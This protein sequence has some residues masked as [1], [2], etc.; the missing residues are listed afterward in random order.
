MEDIRET[1]LTHSRYIRDTLLPLVANDQGSGLNY[2]DL[3]ILRAILND[4]NATPVTLELLRYSRIAKALAIITTDT[5]WPADTAMKASRIL[6][7]WEKPL[8][9]VDD[10][11]IDLWGP[12]G[13][14]EGLKKA[15][16]WWP[17]TVSKIKVI[18]MTSPH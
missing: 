3:S 8:G 14:L 12:G 13:R 9:R 5:R 16:V 7:K 11:R 15:K 18:L 6:Q 17:G 10:L 4:V 2:R 1:L